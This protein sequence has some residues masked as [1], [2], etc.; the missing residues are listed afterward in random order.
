[1][2][3]VWSEREA[4]EQVPN[5]RRSYSAMILHHLLANS[6]MIAIEGDIIDVN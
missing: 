1:M 2:V 3:S 4:I 6:I 5:E